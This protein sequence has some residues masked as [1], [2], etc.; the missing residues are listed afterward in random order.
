MVDTEQES[1]LELGITILKWFRYILPNPK[2]KKKEQI[3]QLIEENL[4]N[5]Y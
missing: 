2:L 3:I 4:I 1:S 5:I